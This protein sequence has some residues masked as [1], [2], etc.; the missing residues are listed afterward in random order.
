MEIFRYR[1][2]DATSSRGSSKSSW[3]HRFSTLCIDTSV[4][5]SPRHKP[6]KCRRCASKFCLAEWAMSSASLSGDI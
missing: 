1:P 4:E 3:H 5:V 6:N 2:R